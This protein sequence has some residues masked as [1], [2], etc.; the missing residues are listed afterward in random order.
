MQSDGNLVL[1]QPDWTAIWSTGTYGQDCGSDQCFVTFQNDGNLVV[2]NGSTPLW[3][4]G[5]FGN[6][7]AELVLPAQ[8]PQLEIIGS[9]QAVLWS[10]Q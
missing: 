2:Y 9:N 7:G 8:T 1:Y 4:S 10:N 6:A 5:T 3:S